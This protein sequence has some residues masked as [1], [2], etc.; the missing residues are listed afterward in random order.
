MFGLIKGLLV[1]NLLELPRTLPRLLV[2][3]A[4]SAQCESN[5]SFTLRSALR[6][7]C[8]RHPATEGYRIPFSDLS[9]IARS[10]NG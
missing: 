8:R 5:E 1:L 9:V 10:R 2:A 3:P 4:L 6:N 7:D